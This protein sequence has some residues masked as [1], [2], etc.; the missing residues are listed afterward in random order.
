MDPLNVRPEV[1]IGTHIKQLQEIAEKLQRDPWWKKSARDMLSDVLPKIVSTALLFVL[2]VFFTVPELKKQVDN[3][4]AAQAESDTK[5]DSKLTAMSN[6]VAGRIQGIRNLVGGSMK[7]TNRRIRDIYVVIGKHE[8]P[9]PDQ[10]AFEE[11]SGG[12]LPHPGPWQIK[13]GS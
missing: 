10:S 2:W 9:E 4:V 6:D 11:Y 1:D 3:L 8:P 7:M 5:I 13:P 12:E